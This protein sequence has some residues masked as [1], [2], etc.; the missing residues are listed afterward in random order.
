MAEEHR[1]F[2]LLDHVGVTAD[3]NPEPLV[4]EA[5]VLAVPIAR[6]SEVVDDYRHIYIDPAEKLGRNDLARIMPGTRMIECADPRVAAM[7]AANGKYRE[8]DPPSKR[9]Q[10]HQRGEARAAKQEA[11]THAEDETTATVGVKGE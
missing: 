6:G 8:I 7:L 5:M 9:E 11:G 10:A 2:E 3:G 4:Q 1:Y